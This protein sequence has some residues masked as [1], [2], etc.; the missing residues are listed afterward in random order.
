MVVALF[1]LYALVALYFGWKN[2]HQNPD[3]YW[4]ASRSL[5]GWSAGISIS[6][7]FM[8]VSWSCVYSTQ[9]YYWFGLAAFWM[10]T[11]PWLM[12]LMIIAIIAPRV[13]RLPQF[14]QPEMAFRRYGLPGKWLF[15]VALI[16]VFLIW[17][18]AEIYIAASLLLPYFPL[19]LSSLIIL[20]SAVVAL[21]SIFGGFKAVVLTDK[22][23]Y[24]LVVLYVLIIAGLGW[25][26]LVQSGVHPDCS[27]IAPR[28]LKPFGNL[29]SI[30]VVLFFLTMLA[31]L[32]G[33]IFESDIWVRLQAT[34]NSAEGRKAAMVAVTNS[35]LFVGVLP[36]FIAF[37]T[38]NIYPPSGTQIPTVL[39]NEADAIFARLVQDFAPPL[40]V[41]VISLGLI[42]AS[43]STIDTCLNI[44]S[45]T[46]AYDLVSIPFRSKNQLITALSAV[47]MTGFALNTSSLWDLFYL[48]SGILSTTIALPMLG[49]LLPHTPPRPYLLAG[50]TGFFTAFFFYFIS[51]RQFWDEWE[52]D[53]LT[54][55]GISFILYAMG[56]SLLVFFLAFYLDATAPAKTTPNR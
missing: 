24:L 25:K 21:Y 33:W 26:G 52:P 32:P 54:D 53:W 11:F 10:I 41:P 44:V 12:A 18:G 29:F 17:G 46:G 8:S 56:L 30:P 22:L 34:R 48:S 1:I 28:S 27:I 37:L 15:A 35:F 7:S 49:I 31:Y 39:G 47:I 42:A 23:Q 3:D 38:L 50:A 14:S 43:M 45:M 5:D 6:A 13:R 19:S 36:A 51:Q 55:S 2:R 20:I 40:L 4:T 16:V 9:L